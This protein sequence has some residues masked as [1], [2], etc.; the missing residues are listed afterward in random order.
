[1]SDGKNVCLPCIV[2]QKPITPL[3]PNERPREGR[4][5]NAQASGAIS[6]FSYGN[7]GSAAFDSLGSERLEFNV[8]DDCVRQGQGDGLI[9]VFRSVLVPWPG[10]GSERT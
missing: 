10:V 5:L 7:Y 3:F 2:C 4:D 6:C 9:L 8:C 1:V